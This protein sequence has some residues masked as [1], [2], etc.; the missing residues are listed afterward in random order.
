MNIEKL[1]L[2][3]LLKN[4]DYTR[5]TLPFLKDEYFLLEDDRIL[6]QTIRDF[7]VKYDTPPTAEAVSLE[8][9]SKSGLREDIV[10][11]IDASLKSLDLKSKDNIDWL[12]DS[13]EKFC[14]EKAIYLAIMKSI[15]IMDGKDKTTSKGAIPQMLSDAIA[16]TFDPNVGHDYLEDYQHRYEYYHRKEEKIPFDLE[17]LNKITNGGASKKT[18]NILMGGPG[19]GKSLIMGHIAA[20]YL[21]QGKNVLYITLELSQEE[22]AKRIDANM[23]NIYL[24]DLMKMSKD[25]YEKKIRSLKSKTNGKL[26]I[27][28]YPTASASAMH[29][30]A[31]LNELRLKKNFSP[32]AIFVDYI[33]LCL[34]SRVRMGAG[35]NS[36]TYIKMI[37]E[38]LRGLAGEFNLPLWTATQVNREGFKSSDFGMENTSESFGLPATADLFLAI[39][40]SEQMKALNQIS[41]K[42]LKN[43]YNS[44]DINSKFVLGIDKPKFKLYDV[45]A[46]AQDLVDDNQEEE[47]LP[48]FDKT[49]FAGNNK[50]RFKVLKVT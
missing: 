4:E 12:I 23:M 2:A 13:T 9:N 16:V 10:R 25:M 46:S 33:N 17:F 21:N 26:I 41:I 43:R 44:I 38:E 47:D 22:I 45:E 24:D 11:S 40:Q 15:E 1:V 48:V 19:A 8:I 39:I 27:K 30:K 14:Q 37:S 3:N 49:S 7:I 6:F 20:S 32:D 34:S 36:Y 29:F 31:L 18:L 35:V 50:D 28:E 5:R 42:Q